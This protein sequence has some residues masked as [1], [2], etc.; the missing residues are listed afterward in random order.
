[1]L[2]M[3]KKNAADQDDDLFGTPDQE[4]QP[5]AVREAL[6]KASEEKPFIGQQV[7]GRE[8]HSNIVEALRE[9]QNGRA[10]TALGVMASLAGFSCLSS[11]YLKYERGEISPD[12]DGFRIEVT[13]SGRRIFFGDLTSSA[14]LE[15]EMSLWGMVQSTAKK[16]GA[17]SMPDV[18]EISAH[19]EANCHSEDYGQPRIAR[20]HMPRDIPSNFVRYLMPSYLPLL[21]R[22]DADA[23]KFPISFGFAI[24]SLMEDNCE[25]LDPSTAAK[26]VMECAIPMA[27]LDPAE[28]F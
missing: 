20:E 17:L 2:R 16:L 3:F 18:K 27:T 9:E 15:G 22:Y 5:R 7:T 21:Q 26:I 19:V 28:V 14:L 12:Q 10:E 6:D 11:V 1:M 8:L 4:L 25:N 23:D 24:Q 13:K